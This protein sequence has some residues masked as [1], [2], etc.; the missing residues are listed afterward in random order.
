MV[1]VLKYHQSRFTRCA[2]QKIR[3]ILNNNVLCDTELYQS[4]GAHFGEP[5]VKRAK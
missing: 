5:T 3:T 4:S 2:H 1:F